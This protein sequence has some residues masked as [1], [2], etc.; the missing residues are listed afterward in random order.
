VPLSK[1][2]VRRPEILSATRHR[3]TAAI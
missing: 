3:R 2:V 1:R